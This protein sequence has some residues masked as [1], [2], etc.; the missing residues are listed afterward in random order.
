MKDYE[1][2]EL[3]SLEESLKEIITTLRKN[4]IEKT[5]KTVILIG[6]TGEGKSTLINYLAGNPLIAKKDKTFGEKII[7]A[8][9]V[10]KD[11]EIG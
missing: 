2:C 6:D 1:K 7:K 10:L 5:K 9:K 4:K 8:I 3:L 11:F